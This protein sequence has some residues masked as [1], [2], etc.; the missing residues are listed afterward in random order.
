[1]KIISELKSSKG[2]TLS[3]TEDRDIISDGIFYVLR[4]KTLAAGGQAV[5]INSE[6]V[7]NIG[8]IRYSSAPRLVS[9]LSCFGIAGIL[10]KFLPPVRSVTNASKLAANDA[11][12]SSKI[13]A[14]LTS[15]DRVYDAAKSFGK[16]ATF[17]RDASAAVYDLLYYACIILL[18]LAAV[19]FV[20]YM[21]S[22]KRLVEINTAYGSFCIDKF[23][24]SDNELNRFIRCFNS[25]PLGSSTSRS[26]ESNKAVCPSCSAENARGKKFCSKCGNRLI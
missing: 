17:V 16:S 24:I 15:D 5:K 10:Y 21:L 20:R 9:S 19:Q 22:Y 6:D 2:G 14:F 26:N 8:E 12:R 18:I 4:D 13:I 3:I 1:M 25:S 11:L 7:L 23:G